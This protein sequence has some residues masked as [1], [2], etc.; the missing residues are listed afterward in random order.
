MLPSAVSSTSKPIW[1]D[2]PV[3]LI[4]TPQY[5]TKKTDVFTTGATHMALLHNSILRGY[6][7]IFNQIPYIQEEDKGDFV[8][9]S[10]TWYKFVKS[11]HDDE[12]ANLFTKIEG[13]LQDRGIFEESCQEHGRWMSVGTVPRPANCLPRQIPCCR[14]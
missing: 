7:S 5:Q 12:Q 4:T 13:L 11:H 1:A 2:G 6:N 14:A 3:E 10:L 9:Y 8:R